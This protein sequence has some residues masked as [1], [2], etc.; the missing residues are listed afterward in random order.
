MPGVTF[1]IGSKP[2]LTEEDAQVLAHLIA[3]DPTPFSTKLA[4]KINRAL[5]DGE[6]AAEVELERDELAE[7]AD[8]LSADPELLLEVPEFKPLYDEI[9]E[10]L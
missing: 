3:A 10:A 2:T 6:S 5:L 8:A 7:I 9:T 4:A 1:A